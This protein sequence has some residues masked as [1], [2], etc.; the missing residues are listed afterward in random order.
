M[1]K[2]QQ[3]VSIVVPVFNEIG[4]LPQF[5]KELVG[6]LDTTKRPYEVIYVDDHSTD[7]TYEWLQ[8]LKSITP[9]KRNTSTVKLL[10]KQGKKGKAYSLIEGF[11]QA[12]G[13]ILAMIDGDLQYPPQAL[14][15][16]ISRLGKADIV[17]AKRKN[18]QDSAIRRAM[19]VSFRYIFGKMLFGLTTDIQS[20]LK[21][22]T[23]EVY[24]TVPMTAASGWT[25][26]LS[27]LS[28]AQQAGFKIKDVDIVFAVRKFGKS[29]VHLVKTAA[30]IGLNALVVKAQ[31]QRPL[32]LSP[33]GK[34]SMK[35]AGVRFKKSKYITHTTLP[36]T[37]SAT[38]TFTETQLV[39]IA[40]V[41]IPVILSAIAQPLL[42]IQ[43]LVA[44]MSI[45]YSVDALFNFYIVLKSLRNKDNLQI[46]AE[47]IEKLD[48]SSLPIYS[49]LCPLYREAHVVPQFVDA[50][51]KME[52]PKDKLDVMLLLEEDDI[53]T[54]ETIQAMDLPPF[55][56]IVVVPHSMPKTKPKACNYGLAFARGEYL[57]IYDAE[58]IPDP[59]QL[60]KAYIAFKKSPKDVQCLQAKLNYYNARQNLLTRFFAAEYSLWFGVTLTGIQSLDSTIPLG[61]TSNHF[62]TQKL[63]ELQ[64]WDPFNV[65]EDADLGIRL[66]QNGYKTAIIDSTTLEEATSNVK[67]WLRQR[68]RWTKGYM[69]TYLVHT[70]NI[71]GFI[72]ANGF[73]HFLIFQLTVG[74]KLL[75][76]LLNPALWI[77]TFL[78]FAAFPLVGPLIERIYVPP[79]SY[80]A[81]F[82]WIFGNFMFLY[83]YM[84]GV[85]RRGQWDI[86]KYVFLIPLYWVLMSISAF[87]AFYQ[88][89]FK[90]H[91]WEKTIH[92][93]H[94]LKKPTTQSKMQ[95]AHPINQYTKIL[96]QPYKRQTTKVKEPRNFFEYIY[97]VIKNN[98]LSLLGL[99]QSKTSHK[100]WKEKRMNIL[101]FNWRDTKHIYNGGAEVYIHELAKRWVKEGNKVT[102][103]CGNDNKSKSYETIDGVEIIRK[104]G[105]YTVYF[106]AFV[107]YLLKFAKKYDAVIDCE[108]GIP[109]FTPL[110]VRKP[111]ILVIHHVHQEVFRTFLRFP[112]NVIAASL[113]GKLMPFLYRNKTVVTVSDSSRKE[114]LD[115]GFSKPDDIK[116]VPNGVFEY[117]FQKT[118]KTQYPSFIYLGRL[119]EYKQIDV[120]IKA[121]AKVV[122]NHP[123]AKLSLVGTG[124]SHDALVTLVK[125]LEIEE[126][127]H[128]VGKVSE[129]EKTD[130]F[131]Q[132]WVAVQPS[133]VEGWGITVIEANACGTP[134]IASKVNGLQDSVVNGK[135]GML[136]ESG[137]VDQF[138]ATMEM[139]IID[140]PFRQQL[141][142]GAERW[143]TNFSWQKSSD[144]F[145]EIIGNDLSHSLVN[146]PYGELALSS[147]EQKQ[148]L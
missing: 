140:T 105:A 58:D 50:I 119:K 126:S 66:F 67:N 59:L 18:Y 101:I 79:I 97:I 123:S 132:S 51:N 48:D 113:E 28:K 37:L 83:Y 17:V 142:E 99:L 130:L 121:F 116:I 23:R 52:W 103:F 69:Q 12:R 77:I 63:R 29:Q 22:F 112:L 110:F 21:V 135:T 19:S 3:K 122:K 61:G 24:E 55:V 60:K 118:E 143:A 80:V 72:K 31:P 98:V 54:I 70:R 35:G 137:N 120:L 76:M 8:N 109:F 129:S 68:S 106:F 14:P 62:R 56:R 128:F 115:L 104:G 89:L 26:D 27:F 81:V 87:I 88:L 96:E 71:F 85:A 84:I 146:K 25:F 53:G 73:K 39:F 42:T 38:Q 41:L 90:P 131:G 125:K 107:Y 6:A 13:S 134:V 46:H 2:I 111:I 65:T 10:Q 144:E 45:L 147:V 75:F 93:F 16:M 141:S 127:I 114:I 117:L 33:S 139:L 4:N 145:Y 133:R 40:A 7:G 36:H 100:A 94:L 9:I 20:G 11:A 47:E 136:V 30:E 108:N 92:G 82:S 91:Y 148:E 124:E 32:H 57:V 95:I 74:G 1:I 34:T 86:A 15:E 102:L 43:I 138:A 5:H 64:G 44:I 78:Y 49:I